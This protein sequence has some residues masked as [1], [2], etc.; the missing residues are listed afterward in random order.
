MNIVVADDLPASA[1]DYL[2][3]GVVKAAPNACNRGWN[4]SV[5]YMGG[6]R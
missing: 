6:L 4:V 3:D 2:K 5:R 1:L